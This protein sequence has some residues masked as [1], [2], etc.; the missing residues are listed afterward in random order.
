MNKFLL[1]LILGGG[2]LFGQSRIDAS[3]SFQTDPNKKY[4]IYIPSSY[5]VNSPNKMMLALHPWNVNR[6]NAKSWCDTLVNFAEA[7]NL[8]I[9]S[10]DGGADGQVDDA[11]DIA[12]TT[13][14]LDSM[15]IWYSID[16]AKVYAMGFSWGGKTTYTYGLANADRFGGFIPIGAAINGSSE[17]SSV[18]ANADGKA[19][20]V[21]HGGNDS[22][23][24]RFYPLVGSLNNNNA[25]VETN[26]LSGVGHTIDFANR[27]TILSR[28]FFWVDSVNCEQISGLSTQ[29]FE[30][31]KNVEIYPNPI[32]S[33]QS[34]NLN[35]KQIGSSTFAVKILDLSG[36]TVKEQE[37]EMTK[38]N[39]QLTVGTDSLKPGQYIILINNGDQKFRS[40]FSVK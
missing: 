38:E 20:Y 36:R 14:I 29:E 8:I 17:I 10:P 3:Q 39:S 1:I 7:N 23:N 25:I 15:E 12:F 13:A 34:L 16:T 11:I 18:A 33:G 31:F 6:W 9:I 28:A 2:S 37:V 5:D 27:N 26:L 19:F 24:T 22:P 32:A 21:V 40:N 35:I 30:D 4:S